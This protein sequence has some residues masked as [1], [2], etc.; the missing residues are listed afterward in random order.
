[1]VSDVVLDHVSSVLRGL[2]PA[3]ATQKIKELAGHYG[4]TK[5]TIHRY[6]AVRGIRFRRERKTKG[7]SA[8]TRE[9][10]LEASALQL[11]S[12]RTSNEIPLP[13]CDAKEILEDSGIETGGVSTSRFVARLRQEKISAKDILRPA[14][15]QR[16][17]SDY[18]NHVWQFDVT[19]C[20]QYFLD[21]KKGLGERD[22]EM[23]MYKNK[24]VKTAKAIKKELLRYVVVDHCSGAFYFQYFYATGER[25]A[26]GSAFLF[27]A[28]RPKDELIK[29][30][31][32]G[33]SAPKLGKFRMHGVPFMLVCDRGSIATAKANQALFDALH[34]ELKPHMPGNPRAK[35]AV[36][37]MMHYINRFEARLKLERPSDLDE[38]NRWALDWGIRINGEK[39]MRGVAPRSILWSYITTEQLRLCPEE[40]LFRLLIKEPAFT[41]I[42]D[43]SCLISVD[44]RR[45]QI[46]DPQAAWQ[47]VSVVR[48]PYEYPN[49][50]VHCN[51]NVWL[52]QPIP[53]DQYGR[54][55]NGVHYGEYKGIKHTETQKTKTEM[56]KKAETWGLKWK[57]TGDKRMAEA[58]PVGFESPLQV[59]GHHADKVGNIEFIE[60]KGTPLEIKHAEEPVNTAITSG[61][62][63][64]PRSVASRKISFTEL[65]K[66]L[67]AEIGTIAPA[68]NAELRAQYEN[69]IEINKAEEVIR[70]INDGSWNAV[71]FETVSLTG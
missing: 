18:P 4:V 70:A 16:L 42:V 21:E 3:D 6:A 41:R 2:S 37:G 22:T 53:E 25:A 57:G 28:M 64:V 55:T 39:L 5:A 35:G 51:G 17:L 8:A 19:N 50:E 29:K 49:I 68:L 14:P 62:A 65:L 52:C 36:E 33:E 26:D 9:I 38:L 71:P 45:Y 56:E 63:E 1:M 32:N 43:G 58:P 69:G 40:E 59:F 20:L 10:L 15:H 67:R 48:H 47:K 24:I 11:A 30:L 54:L 34:I 46:P 31:W 44:N 13:A 7:Q 27:R 60:R 23:T 66:K 61:A 12:R